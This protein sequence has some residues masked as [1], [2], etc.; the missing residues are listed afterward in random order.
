VTSTSLSL[1]G[2][3][4]L[5]GAG[6]LVVL[7]LGYVVYLPLEPKSC[8]FSLGLLLG[9]AFLVSFFI[10][11]ALRNSDGSPPFLIASTMPSHL[12]AIRIIEGHI[13]ISILEKTIYP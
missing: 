6:D 11:D 3:S 1:I 12:L 4:C 8:F 5:G 2:V 9:V 7:G 10:G 13:L